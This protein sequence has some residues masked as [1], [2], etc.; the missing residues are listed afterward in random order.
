VL[1]WAF[2]FE[3]QPWFSGFR[4]LATNGV[5]KPILNVFNMYG[6]MRGNRLKVSTP[7]GLSAR[8]VIKKGV[9]QQPDINALAV[10]DEES[11]SIMIWNYHD[12]N[13]PAEDAEIELTIRGIKQKQLLLHHYRVDRQFSNSFETWKGMGCPQNPTEQQYKELER[14]G[15]LQLYMSPKWLSSRDNT[16]TMH[17]ML[18]R[19]AVSLLRLTWD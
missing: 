12:N 5:N 6:L 19:Q 3:N 2:E 17:F 11:I 18:P 16:L 9:R 7:T 14:S 8:D 4:D 13:L 1:T 10:R 15:Q